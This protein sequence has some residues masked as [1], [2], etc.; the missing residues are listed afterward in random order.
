MHPSRALDSILLLCV[1]PHLVSTSPVALTHARRQDT[2]IANFQLL[3]PNADCFDFSFDR[4][5]FS[6]TCVSD[7]GTP[8]FSK[9]DLDACIANDDGNMVYRFDPQIK[10]CVIKREKLQYVLTG[11]G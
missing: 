2:V 9:I 11:M 10:G 8:A 1:I 7:K 4:D 5:T 6:A 3:G